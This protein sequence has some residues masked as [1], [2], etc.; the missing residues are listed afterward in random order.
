MRCPSAC[1]TSAWYEDDL[2]TGGGRPGNETGPG[3]RKADAYRAAA[4]SEAILRRLCPQIRDG[5]LDKFSAGRYNGEH[6]AGGKAGGAVRKA[7]RPACRAADDDYRILTRYGII[8][9]N[10][11]SM[12]RL[13]GEEHE[14]EMS[15]LR[16]F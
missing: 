4:G 12:G 10:H 9:F 7:L 8:S 15:L 11:R 13:E 1:P 5:L 14:Y 6:P 2:H 3:I 16:I